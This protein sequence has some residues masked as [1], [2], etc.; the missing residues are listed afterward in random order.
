M[1]LTNADLFQPD[2]SSPH[3][4][5]MTGYWLPAAVANQ[6]A[7]PGGEAPEEL[8]LTLCYCGDTGQM[9]DVTIARALIACHRIA[10]L[11]SPMKG[12]VGGL[13]RFNASPQSDGRDVFAAQVDIPDLPAFRQRLADALTAVGCAPDK[14]HGYTP[15]ITLAYIDRGAAL[16][17]EQIPDMPLT[18]EAIDIALGGKRTRVM[19]TGGADSAA[20]AANLHLFNAK[21]S[22]AKIRR[23]TLDGR[24]HLV[25][26]VIA[27]PEGVMNEALYTAAEWKRSLPSWNGRPITI[28]HPFDANG[29]PLSA[30]SPDMTKI[31]LGHLY[32]VTFDGKF[33]G[34]MWLDL[35]KAR[36]LGGDAQTAVQRLEKGQTIEV[37]T[38]LF[39]DARENRGEW[40]GRKHTREIINILPDHLAILLYEQGAC[41]IQDGCG[42]PRANGR[43]TD[44]RELTMNEQAEQA[45]GEQTA[46]APGVTLNVNTGAEPGLFDRLTAWIDQRLNGA[47]PI[48]NQQQAVSA[49]SRR[50]A[51]ETPGTAVTEQNSADCDCPEEAPV[52]TGV[53]NQAQGEPTMNELLQLVNELGGVDGMR[54]ALQ[55]AQGMVVNHQAQ[56][57]QRIQQ[58]TAN[59]RCQLPKETLATLDDT[60]LAEL[61]NAYQPVNYAG[62]GLGVYEANGG[63]EWD[64]VTAPV[65]VVNGREGGAS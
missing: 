18:I 25:V 36:R 24:P 2:P 31:T 47:Q 42:A 9:E 33:R 1:P 58:L 51:P 38:G 11:Y 55:A 53:T 46:V 10:S 23:E 45:Q 63:D 12:K 21:T 40:G 34:E 32:N 20:T 43:H 17:R 54:T 19:L 39:G 62:L 44:G 49:S 52:Q 59:G 22:P 57:A 26:P 5:L 28:G 61:F 50:A 6:L 16:P 27:A 14:A 37:S 15:H 65:V 8:H 64:Y 41:S 35:D 48:T 7:V 30:N 56:R 60:V 3:T 4:G 29:R 13:L